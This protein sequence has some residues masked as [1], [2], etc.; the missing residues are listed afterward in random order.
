MSRSIAV[1]VESSVSDDMLSSNPPFLYGPSALCFVCLTL[2][3]CSYRCCYCCCC[4]CVSSKQTQID[5]ISYSNSG[6]HGGPIRARVPTPMSSVRRGPVLYTH[7]Q[8]Q[9]LRGQQVSTWHLS[10][11][12]IRTQSLIDIGS[13]ELFRFI[14]LGCCDDL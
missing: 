9:V 7:V 4:C 5:W 6:P 10:V 12:I 8:Q 2:S 14:V 13:H 1:S 3:C 11:C